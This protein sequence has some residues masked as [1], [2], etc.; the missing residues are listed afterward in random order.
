VALELRTL[1]ACNV[2]SWR[3]VENCGG[4]LQDEV[5]DAVVHERVRRYW[6]IT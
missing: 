6:L 2:G 4:T 1:R 3:I 5:W